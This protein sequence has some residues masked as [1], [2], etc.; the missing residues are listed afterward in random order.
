MHQLTL[1][2]SGMTCGRCVAHVKSALESVPGVAEAQ[3]DLASGRAAVRLREHPSAAL[4]RELTHAVANAGY[5]ASESPVAIAAEDAPSTVVMFPL[6][7]LSPA[8]T[9]AAPSERITASGLTQCLTLDVEGMHCAS[10]TGRVAAALESVPGVVRAGVNLATS[11]ASVV[12]DPARVRVEQLAAAVGAAGYKAS[13]AESGTAGAQHRAEAQAAELAGWW[14]RFLIAAAALVL[15]L[16]SHTGWLSHTAALWWQFVLATLVQGYVGWP[17]FAGAWQRLRHFSANMDTLVAIGTVAAYLAGVVSLVRHTSDIMWFHDAVMILTFLALGRF[18]EAKSKG[19]ASEAIRRLLDLTPPTARVVRGGAPTDM[20]LGNVTLD[21][22]IIIH[23]GEKV[24]LDATVVSGRST[25]NEAW[26][27]GESMPIEKQPGSDIFAGTINGDGALTARVTHLSGDTALAQVIRLV[28]A[29]QASKA[30]IERL[31]D[32]VVAWFVPVVLVIAAVTLLA[33]GVLAH[34]WT[35]GVVCAVAVLVVACPCAMGL[36]TPTA[37][38]VA[39]GRGAEH[40]ILIK[41]AQSLEL[42]G[43]INVVALDKTG[44]ITLGKPAVQ[45]LS[46]APGVDERQL[47][48]LAAGVEAGSGH[49]L[50]LAVTEYA[51]RENILPAAARDLQ[52][53]PGEGVASLYQEK[54]ALVGNERLLAGRGVEVQSE[55]QQ[56]LT[57]ARGKGQTPLLVAHAGRYL[58]AIFV[59]DAIA[60]H[61]AEAIDQLHELGLKTLMISGDSHETA[62]TVAAQVGI[63]EVLAQVKPDEKQ[64]KVEGLRQQGAR[65]AMVGDGI[66]D[67]PALAAADLGMALGAGADVA[68][69]SADIVLVQSDLRA[70]PQAIRLSRRTLRT[71][72]Q[73]LAWAF[74]YNVLLIPL[75]AG[76]F[77][78]LLG[79]HLPPVM[80]AAAMAASSVSVVANSLLLRWWRL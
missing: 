43:R 52:V 20:P 28:E 77:I 18:L 70:V 56:P 13:L 47:L 53:V 2:I 41:N 80:A 71:I 12:I 78:P 76:V 37:V 4:R 79:W 49:P 26:L 10:C 27:T 7:T 3:V 44:T 72:K 64:A 62:Q 66:N 65:I 61:S 42:A 1:E 73:N 24:P 22:E 17:F 35:T 32:V 38:M 15:M 33:W 46:P 54:P 45:E 23:P 67:A 9:T 16:V 30:N 5:Q 55:L 29:A 51:R 57:A 6:P 74:G 39:S 25:V 58:G 31:A 50:A 14:R 19:R 40:G 34:D 21:E 68:I 63:D 59:A 8:A 60:P 11:R 69:E 48:S 75:A 36:A